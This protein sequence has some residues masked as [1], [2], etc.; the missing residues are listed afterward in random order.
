M[1]RSPLWLLSLTLVVCGWVARSAS[2]EEPYLQLIEAMRTRGF[3]DTALEYIDD[4]RRSPK[5]PPDV[6]AVL[7]YQEYQ[8]YQSFAQQAK[9]GEAKQA[10]LDKALA[11]LERFTKESP[12][13][14][15]AASANSR[16]A[17]LF[18]DQAK[19][20]IWESRTES[21]VRAKQTQ[22]EE[23][24]ALIAKAR[25]I[26]QS[27]LEQFKTVYDSYKGKAP[28]DEKDNP[29]EYQKWYEAEYNYLRA[30]FDLATCTYQEARTYNEGSEQ[31]N[32][33]LKKAAEE[34]EVIHQKYRQQGVGLF[35]RLMQAKCFHDQ[36]DFRLALGIYNE[37][38]G[39]EGQSEVM[40]ALQ[41]QALYFKLIALNEPEKH[42]YKLAVSLATEWLT[43]NRRRS[44]TPDGLGIQWERARA[45]EKLAG[46]GDISAEERDEYLQQAYSEAQEI[47][48]YAGE[49][50]DLATAMI[51][52]LEPLVKGK[53]GDPKNFGAAFSL[54]RYRV[55]QHKEFSE[56]VRNAASDSEKKAA[57][58]EFDLHLKETERVIRLGLSLA[59]EDTKPAEIAQMHYFL[60]YTLLQ[61]GKPYDAAAVSNFIVATATDEQAVSAQDAAY[62]GLAAA[63]QIMRSEAV[64]E[65]VEERDMM[66]QSAES[67]I[68]RWPGSKRAD[69][70]R[71][72][73]GNVYRNSEQPL[74]AVKYY[75]QVSRD[76]PK[77]ADALMRSGQQYWVAYGYELRKPEEERAAKAKLAEWVK[78]AEQRIK[79]GLA[80]VEKNIASESTPPDLYIVA[81]ISLAEILNSQGR[82]ADSIKLLTEEPHSVMANISVENEAS[83]PAQGPKSRPVA[84]LAYQFLLRAYM[85]L[86]D[87]DNAIKTMGELEAVANTDNP[88][89]LTQ[90]YMELGRKLK[91]EI[92]RLQAEG[93]QDRL[94]SVTGAFDRFL[95]ALSQREST[96]DYSSLWWIGESYASLGDGMVGDS[97]A[98]ETYYAKS[99]KAYDQIISNAKSNP[100]FI[101]AAYIPSINT[102]IAVLLKRQGKYEQAVEKISEVLSDNPKQIEAQMEA[103]RILKQWGDVDQAP[104]KYL[105]ALKGNKSTEHK[106]SPIY[107]LEQL[108]NLI[109]QVKSNPNSNVPDIEERFENVLY[110]MGDT[111]RQ[112][113]LTLG[114]EAQRKDMLMRAKTTLYQ[115]ALQSDGNESLQT[116]NKFDD[117]YQTVQ[118]EMGVIPEPLERPKELVADTEEPQEGVAESPINAG[119]GNVGTVIETDVDVTRKEPN[120]ML[121]AVALLGAIGIAVGAFFLFKP[122]KK[123][124]RRIPGRDDEAPITIGFPGDAEEAP[125]APRNAV[126]RPSAKPQPAAEPAPQTAAE[127]TA[128][129]VAE[130]PVKKKKTVADLT[131]EEK[132]ALKRKLLAQKQAAQAKKSEES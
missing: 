6:K 86:G 41:A 126:A 67:L 50:R 3:A 112:Y 48:L 129:S 54:A 60:A 46:E 91:E 96:L 90:I 97:S 1:K 124:R 36:G 39:H 57:R 45:L 84:I 76:Y 100:D 62:L 72:I 31:F 123:A 40:Q 59:E 25:G 52:R 93:N 95:G 117:L 2:A 9:T 29:T 19:A 69:D 15:L 71:Y 107:G 78:L 104:D 106:E 47:A 33:G 16:Q 122:K 18:L 105:F 44:K 63:E 92:D 65:R 121:A 49:F 130:P 42:D 35:A 74:E 23:A 8:V 26:Y 77:Y 22:Q 68:K 21:N 24:R 81:K 51:Q 128:T 14:P 53:G 101:K 111:L 58:A 79:D 132:A 13:H 30:Q 55:L 131:P 34:Y 17:G 108:A 118:R 11:A 7:S 75:D 102:R 43:A 38:L 56:K 109:Q 125:V 64:N 61:A 32:A 114:D 127:A 4:L 28:P 20:L 5:V 103:T 37:I 85:G 120:Y 110:A 70:A 98:A 80:E 94:Q 113:A 12:S 99:A 87:I 82:E 73:L 10:A 88:E 119:T 27:A 116:W 66:K 83:R 89:A 115:F